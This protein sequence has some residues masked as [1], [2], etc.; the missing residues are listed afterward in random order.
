MAACTNVG[1]WDFEIGLGCDRRPRLEACNCGRGDRR[2]RRRR[3]RGRRSATGESEASA[4]LR[5]RERGKCE[6]RGRITVGE[7]L[8]QRLRQGRRGA[9]RRLPCTLTTLPCK[10]G[11]VNSVSRPAS[12]G[13]SL[14]LR[15]WPRRFPAPSS[16]CSVVRGAG[17]RPTRTTASALLPL[18]WY[19][20]ELVRVNLIMMQRFSIS[21]VWE[22]STTKASVCR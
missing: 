4:R 6:A 22:V 3:L 10:S 14:L 12:P 18:V 16:A 7:G 11:P 19:G 21:V 1:E 15:P 8:W 17:P 2:P 20:P 13:S 9:S 5:G